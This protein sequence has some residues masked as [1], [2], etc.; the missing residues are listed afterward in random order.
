[1]MR[2]FIS[3]KFLRL[4]ILIL[5]GLASASCSN[6]PKK[7]DTTDSRYKIKSVRDENLSVVSS[8][9]IKNEAVDGKYQISGL[10]GEQRFPCIYDPAPKEL[11]ETDFRDFFNSAIRLEPS[12][13]RRLVV[14]IRDV[15]CYGVL[16]ALKGA[17]FL[18]IALAITSPENPLVMEINALLEV[19]ENG[20]VIK[21]FILDRKTTIVAKTAFEKDID[22]AYKILIK[23][24][25]NE[26]YSELEK[27]FVERYL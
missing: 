7:I 21:S 26:V 5:F 22:A 17:P 1:M 13:S 19:E 3:A 18:G 8:I 14:T 10:L 16:S 2:K 25:R 11:V 4:C 27:S 6:L 9:T 15:K 23:T 20:S 12:S 24:Y